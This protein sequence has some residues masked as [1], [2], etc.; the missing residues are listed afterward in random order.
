MRLFHV[1]LHIKGGVSL[2]LIM[3]HYALRFYIQTE[4]SIRNA[5][6]LIAQH[7]NSRHQIPSDKALDY[8][9]N[10]SSF[11]ETLSSTQCSQAPPLVSVLQQ[12]IHQ[13]LL[14]L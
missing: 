11:Y 4:A 14:H 7:I 5:L 6:I 9:R 3:F 10:I 1:H 2:C 8:S 13:T 12:Q